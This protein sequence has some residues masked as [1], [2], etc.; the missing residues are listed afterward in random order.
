M[1]IK[2]NYLNRRS[3][4]WIY[5]KVAVALLALFFVYRRFE[6]E[7]IDLDTIEWP[8]GSL[9]IIGLVITLMT[10]NWTLEALRW[11][12]SVGVFET[13]SFKESLRAVLG[14]LAM[15]WVLPFTSGD[16]IYRLAG[17]QD[18]FKATSAMLVNRAIMMAITTIYGL[19]SIRHYSTTILSY[20]VSILILLLLAIPIAWIGQRYSHKFMNYFKEIE[21]FEIIVICSISILRYAVF[22][23]QFFLL[24]NLFLPE[25]SHQV[26]LLGIGWIFFFK[27]ALPSIL[28]GVGVR[29]ASGLIF[30]AGLGDPGT[31]LIPIFLIWII[32]SVI[33]SIGGLKLFWS[34]GLEG[35][36]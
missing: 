30:F 24:L 34:S 19:I 35:N 11:K 6:S 15:N 25:L 31:I 23:F 33:P 17:L 2:N 36:K 20:D 27:S 8:D 29:E 28:G 12:Y 5:T 7:K 26:L 32:N 21:W 9:G 16:A 10:I 13:V 22:V 1:Q 14:G 18:K 4:V 3:S